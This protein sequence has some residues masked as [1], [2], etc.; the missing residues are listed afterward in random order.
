[1]SICII[2]SASF[3]LFTS[4]FTFYMYGLS[5]IN[6]SSLI[7]FDNSTSLY[8][9]GMPGAPPFGGMSAPLKKRDLPKPSNPLKSF[10]WSKLPD[11]KIQGTIWQD[12]D[13]LKVR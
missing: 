11:L 4:S 5:I 1:M 13:D 10:N 2:S 12:L 3:I 6:L 8:P 7:L 9:T